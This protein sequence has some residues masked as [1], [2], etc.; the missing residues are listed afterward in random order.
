MQSSNPE[1]STPNTTKS[2][3]PHSYDHFYVNFLCISMAW[4][5][6]EKLVKNVFW[7]TPP[8]LALYLLKNWLF[9]QLF[10]V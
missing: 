8:P 6:R 2:S 4:Q 5:L 9:L 1:D 10:C 7:Q 3:N